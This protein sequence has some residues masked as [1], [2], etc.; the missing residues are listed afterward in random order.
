MSSKFTLKMNTLKGM[1]KLLKNSRQVWVGILFFACIYIYVCCITIY[2]RYIVD[3]GETI[4]SFESSQM[5]S[6]CNI[7]K[8]VSSSLPKTKFKGV[9]VIF[10]SCWHHI[11]NIFIYLNLNLVAK[12]EAFFLVSSVV[13]NFLWDIWFHHCFSY[14]KAWLHWVMIC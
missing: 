10:S 7:V 4:S 14:E 5:F 1:K 6:K 3:G 8:K 13:Q 12:M 2:R 9:W 11:N